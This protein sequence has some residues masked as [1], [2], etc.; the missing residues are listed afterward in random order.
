MFKLRSPSKYF[1]FDAIHLARCFFPLLKTVL[2]L[3]ILMPFIASVVF[4]F[5]SP[6]LQNIS[7]WGLFSSREKQKCCSG[8]DWVNREGGALLNIHHSVGRCAHKSPT[9]KWANLLKDSKKN[10]LKPNTASHNTSWYTDADGFLEHSPSQ[11]S[12]YY[13]GP[14]SRR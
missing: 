4:C 12:L 8:R 13:K 5:T 9:M 11:G 2:N 7:L 1:P 3:S 14:L 10:A 6:T